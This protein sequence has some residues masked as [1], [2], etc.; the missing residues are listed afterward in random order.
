MNK[1][2]T[3]VVLSGAV[4]WLMGAH[5]LA[6]QP[7]GQSDIIPIS[8][9]V[10]DIAMTDSALYYG[11]VSAISTEED[12]TISRL[13]MESEAHGQYVMNLSPDTV[14]VDAGNKTAA[15][16]STVKVG[17]RLYVYHSHVSTRSLP[18]QSAAFAVVVNVP[19]DMG[20]LLYTSRC[21]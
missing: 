19:Q 11:T 20:C 7:A 3:A 4:V 17:D 21:V 18:P 8:A 14:W 2:L 10:E 12:G 1:K 13:T 16:S 15:D 5:A 6:A 9:P